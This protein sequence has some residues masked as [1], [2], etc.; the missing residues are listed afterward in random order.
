M[1]SPEVAEALRR[2][3]RDYQQRA[4]RLDGGTPP[5]MGEDRP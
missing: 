3:A 4:A 5:D 1:Q 2:M